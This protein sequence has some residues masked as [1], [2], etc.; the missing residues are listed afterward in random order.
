[1]KYSAGIL[2]QSLGAGNREGIWLSYR[3]V[4]ARIFKRLRSPGIDFKEAIL[5]GGESTPGLL[6]MFTNSNSGYIG[7]RNR[8][9]GFLKL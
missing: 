4:R 3:P 9:L 8:F 2:E 5:P 1:M 6:K 7:W